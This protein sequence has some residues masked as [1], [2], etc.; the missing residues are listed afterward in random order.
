MLIFFIND[1]I[2]FSV[3]NRK[4]LK[5]VIVEARD[6][7]SPKRAQWNQYWKFH[8][9][10]SHRYLILVICT[11]SMCPFWL[12]PLNESDISFCML[13]VVLIFMSIL[14]VNLFWNLLIYNILMS[15]TELIT[16]CPS[17][18][19]IKS[20]IKYNIVKH[21]ITLYNHWFEND[22]HLSYKQIFRSILLI[23]IKE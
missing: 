14:Y 17:F 3:E 6:I 10:L 4:L 8:F 22:F 1:S 13:H 7:I 21:N 9:K 16:L 2:T 15:H 20:C 5:K 12:C 11:N 23:Y 19:T 18:I